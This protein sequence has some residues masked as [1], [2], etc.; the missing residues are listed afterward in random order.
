M[1]ADDIFDGLKS[2]LDAPLLLLLLSPLPG[3]L[4]EWLFL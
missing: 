1:C 3:S 2:F 4:E